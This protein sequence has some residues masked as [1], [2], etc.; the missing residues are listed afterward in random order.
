MFNKSSTVY[1]KKPQK[2][3][4]LVKQLLEEYPET[5]DSDKKLIWKIWD[6]LG[7]I[8]EEQIMGQLIPT[9]DYYHFMDS[10]STESIRRCRQKLQETHPELRGSKYIQDK[11]SEKQKSKSSFIYRE[12]LNKDD[13]YKTEA[14]SAM[15]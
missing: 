5:R 2:V 11:R 10:P 13:Y 1:H 14:Q 7:H 9:I 3:Y 6:S 12:E 15:F 4:D 8:H